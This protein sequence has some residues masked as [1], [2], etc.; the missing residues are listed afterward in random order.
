MLK[1]AALLP[2][3]KQL[4]AL[5]EKDAAVTASIKVVKADIATIEGALKQKTQAETVRMRHGSQNESLRVCFPLLL[6][7][8]ISL[9]IH[10]STYSF[11]PP[12][13][14][15]LL[16]LQVAKRRIE[17]LDENI[18]KTKDKAAKEIKKTTQ[19]K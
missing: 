9:F 11:L 1:K 13:P 6:F 8:S 7:T 18:R 15:C 2:E 14:P 12:H 4:L 3:E 10:S 16:P 5:Q 19:K 17:K